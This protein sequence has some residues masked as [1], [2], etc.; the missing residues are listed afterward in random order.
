[1]SFERP[2]IK[3]MQGYTPG[4]QSNLDGII[5]LNTNENPYPATAAVATALA[6]V[7]VED[8]R[9]Y[10]S[11]SALAFRTAAAAYHGLS[12][13]NIIPTNGGDE[14]LR[15][16]ITT[17]TS[18]GD[19]IA[20]AEPSY[21]LYPVLADIQDC[22]LHRIALDE[23]WNLSADFSRQLADSDAKLCLLVNPHAPTGKLTPQARIIQ[24]AQEFEGVLLVDEAY[25][26]FVDPDLSYELTRELE[27][28]GNVIV[29]RTLSKGYSLAGLRFGYGIGAAQ[30]I[31]PMMDKT[32]DSYN[33]D[34][35]SQLL[36]TA[37]IESVEEASL[38]WRKV[39][40]ERTRVSAAL[41]SM[42]FDVLPSECNF[43][44][45]TLPTGYDAEKLYLDLKSQN[46]LVRYFN[47]PRLSDKLRISIGNDQENTR[48]LQAIEQF[49]L[50]SR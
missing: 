8:L 6:G 39:R 14:L 10:P 5:K 32:R 34:H 37:A 46:I 2:N 25:V 13:E 12:P 48:L 22:E 21:S 41:T 43:L 30:L 50:A 24:I 11:P 49:L 9:R 40:M 4:E 3:R 31:A 33:T 15:L 16:V 19:T 20:V 28:L 35:V 26:D 45:A 1:M 23:D 44:L 42:G 18:A 7:R 47:Q 17:F 29:L 36:A 27:R 38:S